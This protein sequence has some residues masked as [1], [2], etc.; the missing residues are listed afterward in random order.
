MDFRLG[1][2]APIAKLTRRW[3]L[4]GLAAALI[5]LCSSCGSGSSS[6]PSHNAYISFPSSDTIALFHIDDSSGALSSVSNSVPVTH[7]GPKGLA[8]HPSGK[9]LFAANSTGNS[10][11]TFSVGSD[12]SLSQSG[13]PT[14]AGVSPFG[15]VIDHSG[16]F[17]LV[18]NNVS[19][20]ISIF[21]VD[22]G[23]GALTLTN[24]VTGLPNPT[25]ILMTPSGNFVYV[26]TP[27][28]NNTIWGFTYSSGTLTPISGS[29]FQAGRGTTGIA[30]DPG[31]QFLYAANSTDNTVSAFTIA[32][33]T[34]ELA[35]IVGSPYSS[36]AGTAPSTLA[37]DTTGKFL[38][39]ATPG[40]SSSIWVFSISSVPASAGEL[41]PVTGSPFSL[42]GGSS[43]LLMEP[44]GKFFYIGST[45]AS[46]AGYTYDTNT[47][48]PAAI[49]GSP[50]ATGSR[51][52][53]VLIT[54]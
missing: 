23:S 47:G 27:S 32:K 35:P 37:V 25:E 44:R 4:A 50:F 5:I 14:P 41:T 6:H 53:A 24:T 12:G 49:S 46:I 18:T 48:K 28:T 7:T 2:Q 39:V 40:S 30:V 45:A 9:F 33:P 52:G 10:V 15:A 20:S 3:T 13:T 29:P 8:L 51:P 42:T 36:T 16:A 34:G 54:H 31:E 43:F 22:S 26:L 19:N 17:L 21:S 11:S 1:S 38:Y